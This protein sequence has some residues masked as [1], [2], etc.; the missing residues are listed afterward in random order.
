VIKSFKHKGLE[1]FF[2]AGSAKGIPAAHMARIE[3]M[4]D[5][6]DSAVTP[7]DMDIDGYKFHRLR[8]ARKSE[9]AVWVSSN[10]RMVFRFETGAATNVNLEDYH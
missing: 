2:V 3:R 9:Y 10:W 4:L 7:M 8:G 6:L 5:S 1:K